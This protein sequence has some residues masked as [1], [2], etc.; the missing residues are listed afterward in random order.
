MFYQLEEVLDK[1]EE[2][3]KHIGKSVRIKD[4]QQC[5]DFNE[6]LAE[7]IVPYPYEWAR[8]ATIKQDSVVEL[9]HVDFHPVGENKD[10]IEE[11]VY[12][13]DC[14]VAVENKALI[15]LYNGIELVG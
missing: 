8:G 3:L 9:I 4:S 1:K 5:F 13:L 15:Y 12:F 11:E 6:S 7:K 10:D 14:V 2:L